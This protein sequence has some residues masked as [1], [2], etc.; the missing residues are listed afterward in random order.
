MKNTIR[1]A[2]AIG[3]GAAPL[4]F[5]VSHAF[6]D[7]AP[8]APATLIPVASSSLAAS[9]VSYVPTV[10]TD[11]LPVIALV[12]GIPFAFWVITK[13]IGFIRKQTATGGKR[14]A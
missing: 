13:V 11:L 9:L 4:A 6:A 14:G 7:V 3:A 8:T 10:F 2:L 1:K 5:V 12:V